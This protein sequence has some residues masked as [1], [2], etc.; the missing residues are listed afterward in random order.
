ML[1]AMSRLKSNSLKEKTY[2]VLYYLLIASSV[3]I[4][5]LLLFNYK[6]LS[7]SEVWYLTPTLFFT[8]TTLP[9]FSDYSNSKNMH[10]G[11]IEYFVSILNPCR[12]TLMYYLDSGESNYSK[13][14]FSILN[15]DFVSS[16]LIFSIMFFVLLTSPILDFYNP[17]LWII[18][19]SSL[20]IIS[21]EIGRLIINN[22][23]VSENILIQ[24][25]DVE[26]LTSHEKEEFKYNV[27]S[28]IKRHGKITRREVYKM[29]INELKYIERRKKELA[30]EAVEA[31]KYLKQK[32]KEE[33]KEKQANKNKKKFAHSYENFKSINPR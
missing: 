9:A 6:E 12:K 27:M 7:L 24:Y 8:L 4:S 16:S 15:I 3:Y 26:S 11:S 22:D 2:G 33:R 5:Y 23:A 13:R 32:A 25:Y 10:R 21:Y 31:K 1:S 30:L 19:T 17:L 18:Y 28:Q 20:L 14:R 29:C